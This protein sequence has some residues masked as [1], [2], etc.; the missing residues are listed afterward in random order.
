M[1]LKDKAS[2]GVRAACQGPALTTRKLLKK[3]E[4][5]FYGKALALPVGKKEKSRRG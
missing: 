2:C 3:L 5:N 4:Q 1:R